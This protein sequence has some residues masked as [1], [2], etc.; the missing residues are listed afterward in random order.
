MPN[1]NVGTPT[2]AFLDSIKSCRLPP[3]VIK[4]LGLTFP[5]T[6]TNKQYGSV[7]FS[8]DGEVVEGDDKN[9]EETEVKTASGHELVSEKDVC[10]NENVKVTSN[11]K[12]GVKD[13]HSE[14][15]EENTRKRKRQ[16]KS[17][18]DEEARNRMNLNIEEKMMGEKEDSEEVRFKTLVLILSAWPYLF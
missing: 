1:G 11:D 17:W 3:S 7:P 9:Y 15:S 5:K 8:Y 10:D 16:K 6:R 12:E 13:V 2:M 4:K 14:T 18:R